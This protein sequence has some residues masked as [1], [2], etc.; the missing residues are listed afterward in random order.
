MLVGA[1]FLI[2]LVTVRLA[3]GR[4]G[5]LAFV[6]PRAGWLLAAGLGLQVLIISIA[7][8]GAHG[9]HAATHLASYA[10]VAAFVAVNLGVPYLW[11]IAFGGMLNLVA[12]AANGG[13]MPADPDAL[14]AAGIVADPQAFSN[15]TAVA[16]PVLLPLGDVFWVPA[17]WPLSNV[18]S[19]G[20]VVIVVGA[21]LA[22][23]TIGG[24]RLA[25]RRFATPRRP[26]T[27]QPAES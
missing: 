8:E 14:A 1:A 23:H 13:V 15:S 20:D 22:L 10:L 24:S 26:R 3:G 11:L 17:S 5:E 12:I 7:P 9:L 16:D 2:F 27:P 4:L 19:V 25:V 18:F 6:R 21:F